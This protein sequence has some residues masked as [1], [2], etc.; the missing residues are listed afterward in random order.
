VSLCLQVCSMTRRVKA[1]FYGDHVI[2]IAWSLFNSHPHCTQAHVV[3]S[4]DKQIRCFTMISLSLLGG[5][6][7][8]ANSVLR[9]QR[10]NRNTQKWTTPKRVQIR[11][12][13]FDWLNLFVLFHLYHPV[14]KKQKWCLWQDDKD[15][16]KQTN[17]ANQISSHFA[18]TELLPPLQTWKG[19]VW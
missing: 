17:L 19:S 3:E 11:V 7:Q 15:G 16:T 4:L 6:E 18:S 13:I 14:T 5:F 2:T 1:P 10:S 8:A 12:K 9:I